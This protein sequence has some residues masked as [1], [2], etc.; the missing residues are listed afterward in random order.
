MDF[1]D[2][3]NHAN[4]ESARVHM[5]E[6]YRI[7]PNPSQPRREFTDESL[8]QLAESIRQHGVLQPL[9]VRLMP[10]AALDGTL[11]ELVDGER[12]LRA[13]KLLGMPEVPCILLA[14]DSRRSA[15][16]AIIENLQ[17]EDLNLFEQAQAIASLLDLYA[18]TQEEIARK[19]SVSQSYV[20]NKL[21]ILRLSQY[22]RE[23]ILKNNLTERHARALLRIPTQSDRLTVL[24]EMIA[25]G[26]NV[27]AAEEFVEQYL[28]R[29]NN[30]RKH[31]KKPRV[32]I[33]D[34][35]IFYNTIDRAIG[36][37]R[38]AGIDIVSEK[39]ELPDA[40]ELKIRIP[41]KAE[42]EATA[43][44]APF[45]QETAPAETAESVV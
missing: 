4:E 19:L 45:L 37:V 13:A 21:R 26:M 5:I 9:T 27:S 25:R 44:L 30:V 42:A 6:T 8:L 39:T 36:T 22:E 43:A 14:V 10:Q 24:Q 18:M 12:R 23:L 1:S 28:N 35:R 15:E 7:R 38:R 17:R 34:I 16:L 11:F 2:Q 32:I 41:K 31:A 29:A 40:V 33:K 20:A 3:T